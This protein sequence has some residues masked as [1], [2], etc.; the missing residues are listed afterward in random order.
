MSYEYTFRNTASDFF[1]FRLE[2]TYR[3]W[4]AVINF[5]FTAAMIALAISRFSRSLWTPPYLLTMSECTSG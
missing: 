2:N 5:V 1:W 3:S 4:M